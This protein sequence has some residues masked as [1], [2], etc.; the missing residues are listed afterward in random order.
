LKKK[1]INEQGRKSILNSKVK[2]GSC[3]CW[4]SSNSTLRCLHW[5][6]ELD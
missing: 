6:A 5:W 1:D 4:S 2:E 3:Y